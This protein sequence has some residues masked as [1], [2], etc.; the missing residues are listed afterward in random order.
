MA[1]IT[2]KCNVCE[3]N[4]DLL[5][6]KQGLT[7]FSKCV[8]TYGCKGKLL[9]T[10]RNPDNIRESFPVEVPGLEDYS[11]RRVLFDYTQTLP[12]SVWVISHD[13]NTSPTVS[14]YILNTTTKKYDEL[15][16]NQYKITILGTNRLKLTFKNSYVGRAQ[17]VSRNS[18]KSVPTSVTPVLAPFQVTSTGYFVF[19]VPKYLTKFEYPPSILPT[20]QLPYDLNAL[21]IRIEV[22]IK[23]PNEEEEICTEIFSSSLS[24]TPWTG[25]N[26]VLVRKR[27]NYYL[28]SK[29]IL[30]FRTFGGD[31][32]KFSDIPDGTQLKITR[33]DYGTGVL[34]PIPPEGLYIL[35]A[36]TPFT[37]N[38]KIKDKVVD[39]ANMVDNDID[40]FSYTTSDFFV[41][42]SN[43]EKTY[44]EL[45]QV[46]AV[47]FIPPTPSPTPTISPTI[48]Q[49]PSV[50]L[51]KSVIVSA[52]PQASPQPSSSIPATPTPTASVTKSATPTPTVT[53]T[54][55]P[56]SFNQPFDFALVRYTWNAGDGTDLDTRTA[57]IVPPRNI[58]VGWSRADVDGTYL[59]WGGDNTSPNGPEAVLIDFN[60]LS[61]DYPDIDDFSIRLRLNWYSTRLD[62]N[63]GIQFQSYLGGTMQH[64]GTDFVNV[65]GQLVNDATVYVNC[66]S[67]SAGNVDGSDIGTLN[68]DSGTKTASFIPLVPAVTP[69]QTPQPSPT[70]TA[71]PSST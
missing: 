71:T 41:D 67:N 42:Q 47:N 20:P 17:L 29:S 7:T 14:V 63:V 32:L 49:T 37:T 21:P 6:N 25:W 69:T 8:I 53:P 40:Y 2:Y 55:T 11:Q 18:I 68:Y 64:S 28:F 60:S 30:A 12:S 26:E 10:K 65:G 22:S 70:P 57:I 58:D 1:T 52:T 56:G 3:R 15:D 4:I 43:V 35:L 23:K 44:P 45:L 54:P 31:T 19:A 48:S 62:G 61:T 9:K 66:V 59:N 50:S 34:Q 27:R 51:T 38:D 36:G 39:V 46:K 5:E 24:N 33:I 16:Q 13:L